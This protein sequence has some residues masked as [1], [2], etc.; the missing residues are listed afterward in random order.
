M[1]LLFTVMAGVLVAVDGC[2]VTHAADC[3]LL[4]YG[5]LH[6]T[7]NA[8]HAQ[9]THT[10]Q[11]VWTTTHLVNNLLFLK[12]RQ[13][14]NTG[15][16]YLI[17]NNCFKGVLLS[18]I[19]VLSDNSILKMG[20]FFKNELKQCPLLLFWRNLRVSSKPCWHMSERISGCGGNKARDMRY[21][22]SIDICKLVLAR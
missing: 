15:I 11:Q 2:V 17:L 16:R 18:C 14:Y 22:L 10:R 13:E 3:L 20:K 12:F 9:V 5:H 19:T 4:L 1:S 21:T 6:F 8:P 7:Y